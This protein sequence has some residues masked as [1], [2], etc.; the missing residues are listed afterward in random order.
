M[1]EAVYHWFV[2]LPL[3]V[4][5]AEEDAKKAEEEKLALEEGSQEE[6]KE[7]PKE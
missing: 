4:E 5:A 1:I 2:P 7:S 3:L 6:T